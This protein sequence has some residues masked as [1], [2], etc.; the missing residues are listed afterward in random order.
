MLNWPRNLI[1]STQLLFMELCSVT[2]PLTV[3]NSDWTASTR[4]EKYLQEIT[5]VRYVSVSYI[6][7]SSHPLPTPSPLA[8]AIL[9]GRRG[10]DLPVTVQCRLI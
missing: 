8:V 1:S 4:R 5:R 2:E 9:H 3:V 7:I 6:E 10:Y